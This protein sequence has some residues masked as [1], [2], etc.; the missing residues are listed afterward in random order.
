MDVLKQK[1]ASMAGVVGRMPS[2]VP[3]ARPFVAQSCGAC[4][5]LRNARQRGTTDPRRSSSKNGWKMQSFGIGV[6]L[7]TA[8]PTSRCGLLWWPGQRHR[9]SLLWSMLLQFC[10][11]PFCSCLSWF[12]M[13]FGKLGFGEVLSPRGVTL[14]FSSIASCWPF[15]FFGPLVL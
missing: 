13:R 8:P 14:R 12:L 6:L 11:E 1:L 4:I 3:S 9:S 15:F 2:V 7:G 10:V 5:P